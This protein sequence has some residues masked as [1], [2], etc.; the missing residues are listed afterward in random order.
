MRLISARLSLIKSN[1]ETL[2]LKTDIFQSACKESVGKGLV[3][4]INLFEYKEILID[5]LFIKD[6]TWKIKNKQK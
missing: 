2:I 5:G 3:I 6:K 4:G 1:R